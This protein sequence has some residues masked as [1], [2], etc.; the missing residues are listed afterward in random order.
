MD[1]L[2]L[3]NVRTNTLKH[4]KKT[5]IQQIQVQTIITNNY[6]NKIL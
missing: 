3:S 6:T 1:H 2:A 4:C 5:L